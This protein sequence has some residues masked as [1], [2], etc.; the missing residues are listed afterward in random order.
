MKLQK[1]KKCDIK[2]DFFCDICNKFYSSQSSLCNH[3]KKYHKH[4]LVENI[5][6]NK[7]YH[8]HNL[9]E[10]INDNNKLNKHNLVENIN[11]NNKLNNLNNNIIIRKKI[12]CKYCNKNFNHRSSK[13]RHEKMCNINNNLSIKYNNLSIKYNKK[14]F[15][16]NLN[17]IIL[18]YNNKPIKIIYY[19]QQI[20]FNI[21]HISNI[22]EYKDIDTIINNIDDEDKIKIN[23][24]DN[25]IINNIEDDDKINYIN[26]SGLYIILAN[27]N[28][29]EIKLFKKWISFEILPSIRNIGLY[30]IINYTKENLEKYVNKDCVYILHIRDNIFKY[31]NTSHIV[32]RLQAHKTNLNYSNIIKIY[33]FDNMNLSK[34]MENKIKKFVKSININ[35][36]YGKHIEFFEIDIIN[37]NNIINKFDEIKINIINNNNIN[38]NELNKLI[39]IEEEKTRQLEL[40]YKIEQLK[41]HKNIN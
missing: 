31:G 36:Q 5:N 20:Y 21:S 32:K 27:L 33:E 34:E 30:N 6:D 8:K 4:N 12:K 3:N 23:D 10:N 40:E 25:I 35:I 18:S 1:V 26:E 39:K 37:L 17:N 38:N 16:F 19:N 13:S 41:I 7:K 28:K 14:N 11:D 2:T 9:V 15:T 22:L 29:L 24:I